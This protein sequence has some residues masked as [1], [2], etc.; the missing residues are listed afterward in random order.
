ML[1]KCISCIYPNCDDFYFASDEAFYLMCCVALLKHVLQSDILF[2][3]VSICEGKC[4][5]LL[6]LPNKVVQ[7]NDHGSWENVTV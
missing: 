5:Q 7:P 1:G 3:C 2:V 6:Q 4:L